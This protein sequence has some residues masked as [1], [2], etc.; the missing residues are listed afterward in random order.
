MVLDAVFQIR[1]GR[2]CPDALSR[3][4]AVAHDT[5]G[6]PGRNRRVHHSLGSTGLGKHSTRQ[7]LNQSY[8]LLLS[9]QFQGF[10]RDLHTEGARAV[11]R[12]LPSGTLQ[13]LMEDEL[14]RGLKLDTGNPNPRDIGADFNRFGLVFWALVEAAHPRN[15]RRKSQLE[16][17][18]RWRNAIA[19]AAFEPGMLRSGRSM[20][21]L[22]KVRRWRKARDGLARWFDRI[23]RDRLRVVIGTHPW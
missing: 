19:H 14:E 10:C 1:D 12:I 21:Y 17:M 5:F 4:P 9:A 13:R 23:L 2:R 22:A 15:A 3:F 8:A 18:N 7:P 16:Q 11:A 6:D 20:L